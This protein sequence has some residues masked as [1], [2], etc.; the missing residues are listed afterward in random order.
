MKS[1]GHLLIIDDEAALRK[2]LARILQQAGFE[3]TTAENGEQALA[4]LGSTGFDLVYMDLR[5]PG[6]HGLEV[7]KFIR[8][9]YPM[10]PA[11]WGNRLSP[12]AA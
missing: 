9:S 6:M 8:E 7:L 10:L 5:M 11:Q 1:G 12:Q 4:F 2:T 3:V